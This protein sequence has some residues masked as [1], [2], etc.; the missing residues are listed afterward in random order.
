[1]LISYFQKKC[2]ADYVKLKQ[3][4]PRGME[5]IPG[6]RCASLDGDADRIVFYFVDKG[7]LFIL[8][9]DFLPS[10]KKFRLLDGDRIATLAAGYL[11]KL[12]K[13]ADIKVGGKAPKVGIVQTAY[14]NGSST[15]Y[16]RK[17]LVYT[18][19]LNW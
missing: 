7:I 4:K 5:I 10:E 8:L 13:E 9:V 19:F 14:A 6:M 17:T 16:A 2:G 15:E 18:F 11:S 3:D 12:V 1:M